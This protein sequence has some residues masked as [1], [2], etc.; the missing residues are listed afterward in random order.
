ML[1]GLEREAAGAAQILLEDAGEPG[2]QRGV[3][4]GDVELVVESER[5]IVEVGAA[6]GG[7]LSIHDHRLGVEQRRLILVDLDPALEQGTEAPLV[8]RTN[9]VVL[10]GI[11]TLTRTPRPTAPSSASCNPA[12]GRK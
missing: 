6:D 12:S 10:P 7:P 11:S 9:Q 8:G 2:R 5:A 3:V 4:E 1:P